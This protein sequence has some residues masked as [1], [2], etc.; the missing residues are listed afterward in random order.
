MIRWWLEDDVEMM[1]QLPLALLQWA[2]QEVQADRRKEGPVMALVGQEW[3]AQESIEY[4]DG[5]E[6][7]SRW[8]CTGSEWL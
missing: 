1:A 8:Q 4:P 5:V 2:P 7:A 6:F 3:G